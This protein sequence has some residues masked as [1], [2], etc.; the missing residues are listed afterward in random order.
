ML[1]TEQINTN[2]DEIINLLHN[3]K[4]EGIQ[5]LIIYLVD[6]NFF[7]QAASTKYHQSYTGGL[8]EHSLSVYKNL[9]KLNT[10]LELGYDN[11]SMIIA[12]LLHDICKIDAYINTGFGFKWNPSSNKGHAK[13]SINIVSRFIQLTREEEYAIKFHMGA[14]EKNEFDW[15]ELGEGYRRYSMAYYIHV[16]DMRDTYGF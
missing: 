3:T 9:C 6:N 10:A 5:D 7:T 1:T 16:A 12:C 2:K 11:D 13:K 14:Y 8:A 4:R 15:T